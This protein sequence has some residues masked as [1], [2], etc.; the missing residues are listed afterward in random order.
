MKRILAFVVLLHCLSFAALADTPELEPS[1]R[2]EQFVIAHVAAGELADLNELPNPADR[3]LSS[4]FLADL[5][6]GSGKSVKVHRHGVLIAHASFPDD[7]DLLNADIPFNVQ[8]SDC[9]FLA[10]VEL[11]QSHFKKNVVLSGSEF[12][13]ILNFVDAAVDGNLDLSNT[14]FTDADGEADLSGLRVGELLDLRKTVF[15]GKALFIRDDIGGNID[16]REARFTCPN[17]EVSFDSMKVNGYAFFQ[18]SVFVSSASFAYARVAE[19]F[20]AD[21]AEFGKL[22]PDTRLIFNSMK[23]G[24]NAFFRST[25]FNGWVDFGHAEVGGNFEPTQAQFNAPYTAT[26]F[27]G[28]KTDVADFQGASFAN[29]Y[30]LEA[31]TY[32]ELKADSVTAF[33]ERARFSSDAYASLESFLKRQ[34]KEGEANDVYIAQ[35][36]RE[37]SGH[38]LPGR[39]GSV[40]LDL[41]VGYGRRPFLAFAWSAVCVAAGWFV[42]RRRSDMEP[43]K[44]EYADRPYSPFWYSLDVFLPFVDLQ[45]AGF[46]APR[47]DRRFARTYVAIHTLLGWILI[48]IGLAAISGLVR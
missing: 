44:P 8:L 39:I 11:S 25:I 47:R 29:D 19:N 20:G 2:A 16:A 14:R 18:N 45:A 31:M 23:V 27:S 9:H 22:A 4:D 15:G 34:G 37:R 36:R 43:S 1:R 3:V 38:N 13:S 42:F 33:V 17:N 10:D 35:R 30:L 40:L 6:S 21:Q 12:G 24:R 28:M 46:W 5:L 32:R 41:L 7:V 26:N 48:P